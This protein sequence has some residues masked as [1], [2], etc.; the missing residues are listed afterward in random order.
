MN[1]RLLKLASSS[2]VVLF[3]ESSLNLNQR[4]NLLAGFGGRN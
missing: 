3:V 1:T 4:Q 2:D